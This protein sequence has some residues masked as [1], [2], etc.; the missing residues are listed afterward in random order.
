GG[1]RIGSDVWALWLGVRQESRVIRLGC[2]NFQVDQAKE[3]ESQR[4]PQGDRF[5]LHQSTHAK[6]S[7]V[8][9]ATV[10]V[11]KLRDRGTELIQLLVFRFSH[12]SAEGN[13]L[14]TVTSLRG[15]RVLAVF[16]QFSGPRNG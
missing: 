13:V 1:V 9:V 5:G 8:S 10:G 12:P 14:L 7:Q 3:V 6:L 2:E 4:M 11:G 16:D 15:M